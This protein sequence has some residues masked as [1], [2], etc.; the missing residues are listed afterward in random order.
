[1]G[2]SKA[3]TKGFRSQG[4]KGDDGDT[5]LV[6]DSAPFYDHLHPQWV[7]GVLHVMDV[8]Q[9]CFGFCG[10]ILGKPFGNWEISLSELYTPLLDLQKFLQLLTH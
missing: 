6:I 9:S 10:L 8:M 4:M 5:A 3:L 7:M 2:G 1:M